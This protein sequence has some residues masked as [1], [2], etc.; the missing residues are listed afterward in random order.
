[1]RVR[2][3]HTLFQEQFAVL[4]SKPLHPKALLQLSNAIKKD[5]AV[6]NTYN[7]ICHY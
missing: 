6:I 1:M 3:T 7:K 4:T 2:I 5:F